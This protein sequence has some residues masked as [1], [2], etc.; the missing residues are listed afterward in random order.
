MA[1]RA[2]EI[3]KIE[4]MPEVEKDGGTHG[5][6]QESRIT[7]WIDNGKLYSSPL[8]SQEIGMHVSSFTVKVLFHSLVVARN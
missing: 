1:R 7:S 3:V 6:W 2:E 4:G 8:G 5:S